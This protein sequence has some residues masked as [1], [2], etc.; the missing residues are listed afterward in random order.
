MKVLNLVLILAAVPLGAGAAW[1][2]DKWMTGADQ[3]T[4]DLNQFK[5]ELLASAGLAQ[6]HNDVYKQVGEKA[7]EERVKPQFM[8]SV[9]YATIRETGLLLPEGRDVIDWVR[10]HPEEARRLMW[11]AAGLDQK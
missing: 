2:T 9:T 3:G 1:S 7:W 6:L 4:E 8:S 5:K 10:A 11:A